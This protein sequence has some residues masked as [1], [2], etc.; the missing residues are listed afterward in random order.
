MYTQKRNNHNNIIHW[1]IEKIVDK[2]CI[3]LYITLQ[4]KEKP[5]LQ[6]EM[7]TKYIQDINILK[8]LDKLKISAISISIKPGMN[9]STNN[10][11]QVICKHIFVQQ[12]K[13]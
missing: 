5:H 8:I 13:M 1:L 3:N 12:I 7:Y 9:Y 2:I 11:S 6:T 10:T 4:Y